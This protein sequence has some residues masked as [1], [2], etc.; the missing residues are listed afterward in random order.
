VIV[1]DLLDELLIRVVLEIPDFDG[2][3][4]AVDLDRKVLNP[5][6]WVILVRMC[7]TCT[8]YVD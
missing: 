4:S 3:V 6:T 7:T 8:A 2:L 5:T 1:Q